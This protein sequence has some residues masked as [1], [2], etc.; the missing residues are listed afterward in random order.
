M[1]MILLLAFSI[2]S[3]VGPIACI[4][5]SYSR[6]DEVEIT[7]DLGHLIIGAF[8]HHGDAFYENEVQRCLEI[9]EKKPNDFT[10]RNDLGAA[11]TKLARYEEAE[12]EF[13]KNEEL[14]PKKYETASNFGV[15]YKK[16][17][18]FDLAEKQI[19]SALKIKPGG[20]M[21]LG[22]YY[23]KMIQWMKENGA[24]T[25]PNS[26]P[27]QNFLGVAYADSPAKTAAVANKE[28]VITLIKNDMS[29]ADAYMVLGDILFV[30]K[31]MQMAIRAYARANQL[32]ERS[33]N[34]AYR[35]II[36]NR[37]GNVHSYWSDNK[38]P[39]YVIVNNP[40]QTYVAIYDEFDQAESWLNE[41]QRIEELAIQNGEDA[42][43]AS[44]KQ[45]LN[46]RAIQK[47][48]LMEQIYFKG[49]EI[50][51]GGIFHS[52]DDRLILLAAAFAL[53]LFVLGM[54]V[55]VIWLVRSRGT[56]EIQFIEK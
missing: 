16:W 37:M 28:Y 9:L 24:P 17:K 3:F 1:K 22:D 13:K 18:K 35:S 5:T 41:Y 20:H 39:G 32:V 26:A 8:A 19:D 4:N 21:G 23:L 52:V 25:D 7:S 42:S 33:E 29:F 12:T 30:E 27:T 53:G 34:D 45:Q 47:P 55:G 51:R 43:F 54:I 40:P 10:A 15:L 2:Q 44:I 6:N 56:P 46:Q 48:R 14:H 50:H 49:K 38:L 36:S 31:D 11:Y